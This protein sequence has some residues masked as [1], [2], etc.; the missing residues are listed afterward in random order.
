MYFRINNN[1]TLIPGI[2]ENVVDCRCSGIKVTRLQSV[3]MSNITNTL[4]YNSLL[5]SDNKNE[6]F[7]AG[8]RHCYPNMFSEH[9]Q[10]FSIRNIHRST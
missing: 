9:F 7:V 8:Q 6:I 3:F 1:Q 10:N 5:C 4:N 2:D